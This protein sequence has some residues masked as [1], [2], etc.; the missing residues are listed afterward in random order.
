[1]PETVAIQIYGLVDPLTQE[2]R[3]IGKANNP[4]KRYKE[5]LRSRRSTPVYQWVRSLAKPPEM[6]VLASCLTSDWQTV[7][8]QVIAQYR[9]DHSLLNIADG[10]DQPK[11]NHATNR[12]NGRMLAAKIKSDPALA[13][14]Q[15]VKRSIANFLRDM[16]S[17]KINESA[18]ERVL[19]KLRAAGH[20]APHLF[21]EYR[22]L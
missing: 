19:T 9:K 4:Q 12:R 13:R 10:G 1:M 2:V 3:Y 22:F 8:K 7:E 5:H 17:G 20:K 14:V 16:K 11:S 15:F 21:G 18:R 6:V